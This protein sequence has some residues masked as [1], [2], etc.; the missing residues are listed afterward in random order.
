MTVNVVFTGPAFDPAG[1]S[2]LRADLIAACSVKGNLNV[3]KAVRADT[4]VLVASRADTT[5]ARA[6]EG[7][8]IAVLTY[9]DFIAHFLAGVPIEKVGAF[10]HHVDGASPSKNKK[11]Q[12]FAASLGAIDVL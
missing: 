1:Q 11:V 7:R 4:D 12:P 2:V 9:G 5:K 8:G 3:Q 6:A 10:D